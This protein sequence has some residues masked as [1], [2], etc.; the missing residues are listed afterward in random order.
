MSRFPALAAAVLAAAVTAGVTGC[1]WSSDAAPPTVVCGTTLDDGAMGVVV[2][3]A[4]LPYPGG[5]YAVSNLDS[6][7]YIRVAR[8]CAGGSHVTWIPSSAA[9]LVR[10]AYAQDGQMAAVVLQPAGPPGVPFKVIGTRNGK[11]VASITVQAGDMT[12]ACGLLARAEVAR[13][14]GHSIDFVD[15][16]PGGSVPSCA[17]ESDDGLDVE[18][19]VTRSPAA[20][21]ASD[22]PGLGNLVALYHLTPVSGIADQAYG[23]ADAIVTRKRHTAFAIVY[24]ALGSGT[25]KLAPRDREQALK[26]M[27]AAVAS[28]L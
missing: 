26:E 3:D 19:S 14:T 25:Y 17:Y 13:A 22:L 1:V 24:V 8:G 15:Q 5:V 11:V 2:V 12:T 28:H 7:F 4:T 10:A 6:L 9:R 27:A 21:L 23:G 18:L 20:G 16:L